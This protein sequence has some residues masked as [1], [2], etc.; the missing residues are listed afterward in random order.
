M[1]YVRLDLDTS[2]GDNGQLWSMIE[3]MLDYAESIGPKVGLKQ[4]NNGVN[5]IIVDLI[6][7]DIQVRSITSI[8]NSENNKPQYNNLTVEADNQSPES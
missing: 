6:G 5:S 7:T 1:S 8:V 4:Y 3:T 2:K